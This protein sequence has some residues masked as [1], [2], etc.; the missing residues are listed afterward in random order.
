MYNIWLVC[1]IAT[2]NR[3][4]VT[5]PNHYCDNDYMERANIGVYAYFHSKI[6]AKI[7]VEQK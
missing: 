1:E 7:A 5:I 4:V 3:T 6:V 2:Y